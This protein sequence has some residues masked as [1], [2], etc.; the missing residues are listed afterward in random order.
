MGLLDRLEAGFDRVVAAGRRR[1]RAFD[2][3]WRAQERYFDVDAARLAA[4]TAYYGFFAVFA[5]VVVAFFILGRVLG[6][7]EAVVERVQGYLEVN[8]PQLHSDQIFA[9]SQQIGLIALVGLIIA[10]VGWVENLRS[11]Q[12]ALWHLQ[13]HPGNAVVRWLVDLAVLVALGMLLIVSTGIFAGVQELLYWLAGDFEQDPVRVALRGTS[14][15]LSGIVDVI[16]GMALLAGVP[17][18]RMSLRRLLPSALLF[19]VGLG[20]LKTLGKLYITRIETNPAYQLVAGTIGLLLY[21][22]LLHQLLLFAAALAATDTH[23]RAKDLAGGEPRS[24]VK[25]AMRAAQLVEEAAETT[26]RAAAAVRA[27]HPDATG[28]DTAG[29]AA[30]DTAGPGREPPARGVRPRPAD[31]DAV[32]V[33]AD[34][35]RRIVPSGGSAPAEPRD[36]S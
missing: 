5:M 19:A 11:S 34:M 15:L 13:E 32:A 14:T 2:H 36:P 8:L 30:G 27:E 25:A 28:G 22:Y 24:D 16:L 17:R 7:N 20:L 1:S 10:G 21:M 6:G 18:L 31:P 23:G 35:A 26:E 3:F 9:G 33:A 29:S 4:A 12:R